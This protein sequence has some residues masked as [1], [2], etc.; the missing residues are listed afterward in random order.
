M[1]I[2]TMIMVKKI[3]N[4]RPATLPPVKIELKT[5]SRITNISKHTDIL[6][7]NIRTNPVIKLVALL[8]VVVTNLDIETD[9]SFTSMLN[10]FTPAIELTRSTNKGIYR[11]AGNS[12]GKTWH[13]GGG[14]MA[15]AW[16]WVY[17]NYPSQV[18][19]IKAGGQFLY[20]V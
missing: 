6:R 11:P 3:V 10:I 14:N 13:G 8:C 15:M 18:S 2:K 12:I 4:C 9:D 17:E 7:R 5:M 19:A 20:E 16:R 1:L